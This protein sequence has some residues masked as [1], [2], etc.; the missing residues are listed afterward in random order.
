MWEVPCPGPASCLKS[1]PCCPN[2]SSDRLVFSLKISFTCSLSFQKEN[3]L[4]DWFM[5]RQRGFDRKEGHLKGR[6]REKGRSGWSSR[7]G[8]C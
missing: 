6:V 8:K 2:S 7:M 4:I 5:G 1:F 3:S